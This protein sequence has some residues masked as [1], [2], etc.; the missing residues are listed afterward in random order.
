[1]TSEIAIMNRKG[2]ALAADSIGTVTRGENQNT[3]KSYDTLHKLFQLPHTKSV[4][5][6]FYGNA[7]CMG[8]PL[9]TLIRMYPGQKQLPLL[10][11]YAEDFINYLAEFGFSQ[12]QYADYVYK[13]ARRMLTRMV[14]KTDREVEAVIQS[15]GEITRPQISRVL[16]T[17]FD[18]S[19]DTISKLSGNATVATRKR[20]SLAKEH[21]S[22]IEAIAKK[23]IQNRPLSKA[24]FHKISQWVV[25]ACCIN[26]DSFTGIVFAGF[27]EQE[28]FPSFTEID[29]KGVLG[30][31]VIYRQK[32]ASS[33]SLKNDVIIRPF[34]EADDVITFMKGM[35][36]NLQAFL[37]RALGHLLGETLPKNWAQAVSESLKLA[38]KESK[39]VEDIAITMGGAA[40]QQLLQEL[41]NHQVKEFT[42]PVCAATR[43]ITPDLLG[44]MAE[45]LIDLVSFRNE[46]SMSAETVG[47]PIDVAVITKAEGFTWAKQKKGIGIA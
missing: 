42:N 27:G 44:A 34:A 1:M 3:G 28:H 33:V 32:S 21:K 40:N 20:K 45:T 41:Q 6:M 5:I 2:V 16:G 18:T 7:D 29:I 39:R 13:T 25:D 26:P 4:G 36:H 35:N 14:M 37:E 22:G 47:G 31:Q 12:D 11:D 43:H 46:M 38:N 10:N 8:V 19:L 15:T 24:R 9:E 30:G 23:V 17:Q